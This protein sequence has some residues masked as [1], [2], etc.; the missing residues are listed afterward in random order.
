MSKKN[1]DKQITRQERLYEDFKN[2]LHFAE[3]KNAFIVTVN[4]L[5]IFE[6]LSYEG[7]TLS[8]CVITFAM[9]S[10]TVSTIISLVSF[11][12]TISS[13]D[14]TNPLY[15][16][17]YKRYMDMNVVYRDLTE[18]Q[19]QEALFKQ[20]KIL[21]QITSKKNCYAKIAFLIDIA[22][23]VVIALVQVVQLILLG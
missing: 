23:I 3:A 2:W 11:I 14:D 15:Y 20:N 16:E 4:L 21:A 5:A 10:L 19:Y 12:P 1:R 8:I 13:G 22:V 9:I 18:E 17:T 6:L 7:N